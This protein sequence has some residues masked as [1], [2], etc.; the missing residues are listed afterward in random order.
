M[1]TSKFNRYLVKIALLGLSGLFACA[2]FAQGAAQSVTEK[3]DTADDASIAKDMVNSAGQSMYGGPQPSVRK[4]SDNELNCEQIYA[5][6][7]TLQKTGDAQRADAEAAAQAV[8]EAT[9][10]MMQQAMSARGKDGGSGMGMGMVS[11]L[12]SLLGAIPGSGGMAASMVGRIINRVAS[13]A[14]EAGGSSEMPENMKK[15]LAKMME[16][17]QK[18]ANAEGDMYYT[19]A[20]HDYLVD[21]FLKKD[22]KLSQLKASAKENGQ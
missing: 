8:T 21:L 19:Q 3:N 22:C 1:P 16:V 17:Q 2:A 11:S 13:Q 5:E 4:L 18:M 15:M 20:R 7:E 14:T 6:T 9:N 12:T 10:D